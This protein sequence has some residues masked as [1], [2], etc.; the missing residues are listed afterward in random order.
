MEVLSLPSVLTGGVNGGS[1]WTSP[2]VT[3]MTSAGKGCH[4]PD[5]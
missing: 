2:P 5:E 4:G 3:L 1:L